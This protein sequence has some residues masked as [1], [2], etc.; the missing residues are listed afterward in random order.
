MGKGASAQSLGTGVPSII[1]EQ[2]FF[3]QYSRKVLSILCTFVRDLVPS[4]KVILATCHV[5]ARL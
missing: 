3:S 1:E 5:K 2:A 4:F